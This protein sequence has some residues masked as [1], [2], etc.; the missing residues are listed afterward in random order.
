MERVY[1]FIDEYGAFG[2]DIENPT[3][4]THFIIT[5]IIVKES[6]LDDY[7][8][9]TEALRVKHFQTGE[10]KSK[11]INKNHQRRI[12]ILQ[13]TQDIPFGFFSVV[14]DKKKCLEN[15][16]ITGLNYKKPFY[17]FVKLIFA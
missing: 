9:K 15:M 13:D 16:T 1:A 6:D 14:V 12:R 2:W 10:I 11:G 3:V 17:K 5:A 8:A 7:K 4:S